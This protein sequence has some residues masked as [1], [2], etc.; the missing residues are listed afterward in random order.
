MAKDRHPESEDHTSSAFVGAYQRLEQMPLSFDLDERAHELFRALKPF[1]KD[2]P[3]PG[4]PAWYFAFLVERQLKA[5]NDFIDYNKAINHLTL[6]HQ[7]ELVMKKQ[8]MAEFYD[9][10]DQRINKNS[11]FENKFFL[12]M[13]EEKQVAVHQGLIINETFPRDLV[14]KIEF[15][16]KELKECKTPASLADAFYGE[17][18]DHQYKAL[19]KQEAKLVVFKD[20]FSASDLP[21]FNAEEMRAIDDFLATKEEKLRGE[22]V[23]LLSAEELTIRFSGKRPVPG[24]LRRVVSEQNRVVSEQMGNSKPPERPRV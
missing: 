23:S 15:I 21:T 19:L 18:L 9:Q 2:R 13:L 6:L 17:W 20:H 22:G 5:T 4:T 11:F 7:K 16:D 12:K 1:L 24:T 10:K 14:K 8:E 3:E